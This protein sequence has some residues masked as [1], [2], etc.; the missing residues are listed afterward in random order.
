MKFAHFSHVWGKPNMTAHGATRSSGGSLSSVTNS[1]STSASASSIIS[2]ARK[3]DVVARAL[4]CRRRRANKASAGR[5]H[6]L[7][8]AAL[9]SAAARRGDCHHRS[10]AR[11]PVRMRPRAR[12][13]PGYFTPFGIDYNFRKSPT[14]EFVHYLRAAYGKKQP[15]SFHGENH[16]TDSAMLAV[17]PVQKPH[18]PL[19]MMSRDPPTL[20]FCA[21]EGVYTGSFIMVPRQEAGPRYQ[22][23]LADWN[24]AVIAAS[25][26]SPTARWSMSMRPI[27]RRSTP[28]CFAPAAPMKACCRSCARRDL[29]GPPCQSD[30]AVHLPRRARRRQDHVEHF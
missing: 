23:F 13:H 27:R 17:Q 1:A 19:W 16:K 12:H 25:P 9:P 20:E 7:H 29:R 14:L 28:R 30:C 8:R 5:L 18:P 24:N 26:T 21:K 22:K 2:A 11:R 6:G 10:D 3:L 15:F 4:R